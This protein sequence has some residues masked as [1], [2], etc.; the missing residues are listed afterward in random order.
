[1]RYACDMLLGFRK[2]QHLTDG[3]KGAS[4]N[5]VF[6]RVFQQPYKRTTYY[7]NHA[8]YKRAVSEKGVGEI[9]AWIAKG[10][11]EGAEWA[12]FKQAWP[13]QT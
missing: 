6:E 8:Y 5:K 10:R 13:K 4:I 1:M 2:V 3:D 7:D 9:E 11:V 12:A